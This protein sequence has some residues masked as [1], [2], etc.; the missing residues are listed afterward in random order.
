MQ[1]VC[2]PVNLARIAGVSFHRICQLANYDNSE[3]YCLFIW[4]M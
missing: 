2:G 4:N 1:K 3:F